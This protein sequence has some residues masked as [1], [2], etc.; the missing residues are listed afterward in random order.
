MTPRR[1]TGRCATH[2]GARRRSAA[3]ARDCVG[4][5]SHLYVTPRHL[6][7][8]TVCIT[9]RSG[10]IYKCISA[11]GDLIASL[12]GRFANMGELLTDASIATCAP[13]DSTSVDVVPAAFRALGAYAVQSFP[14]G[15]AALSP[16][17]VTIGGSTITWVSTSCSFATPLTPSSHTAIRVSS[18]WP[19]ISR[20]SQTRC[21]RS[22]ARR[23]LPV[24]CSCSAQ[25]RPPGSRRVRMSQ[26]EKLEGSR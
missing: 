23:R 21:R 5:V 19:Q 1:P 25:R 17:A 26:R 13:T 9:S 2:V 22:D 20:K 15:F 12:T 14:G 7:N 11:R 10:F 18:W 6:G 16:M 4:G 24:V 8:D 3:A